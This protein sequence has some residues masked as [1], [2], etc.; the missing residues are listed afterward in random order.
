MSVIFTGLD[1]FFFITAVFINSLSTSAILINPP[2]SS[3]LNEY[4]I[5]W[6]LSPRIPIRTSFIHSLTYHTIMNV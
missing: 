5:Y 1:S 6:Y 3:Y 2:E 4:L